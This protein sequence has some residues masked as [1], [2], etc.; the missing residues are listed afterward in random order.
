MDLGQSSQ[1]RD[2]ALIKVGNYKLHRCLFTL[3]G[4]LDYIRTVQFH[5]ESPWI[6]LVVS[7]SLDQTVRVWDIGA[8]RKKS[9]SPADDILCLSQMNA[10]FFGGVDSVVKYVRE[11]HDRGVNWASFHPTLPL[12]VFDCR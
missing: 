8:L 11:G 2:P 6:D 4:H 5:H 12:I 3:L 7:A 9:V 1:W 10:D